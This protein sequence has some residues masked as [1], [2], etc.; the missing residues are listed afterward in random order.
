MM[1]LLSPFRYAIDLHWTAVLDSLNLVAHCPDRFGGGLQCD[2]DREVAGFAGLQLRDAAGFTFEAAGGGKAGAGLDPGHI[3]F[4]ECGEV[5]PQRN[6]WELG[7]R[8]T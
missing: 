5:L 8:E 7:H 3:P 4:F 2:V 6:V 1:R